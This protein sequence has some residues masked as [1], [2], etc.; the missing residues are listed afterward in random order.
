MEAEIFE[1]AKG[2]WTPLSIQ[3]FKAA[4]KKNLSLN[5]LFMK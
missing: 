5:L 1:S 3:I 4:L 2:I